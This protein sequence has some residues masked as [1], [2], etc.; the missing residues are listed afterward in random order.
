[1]G[2]RAAERRV[3]GPLGVD[4]D[5]LVVAG[6]LGERVDVVLGDL[7]PLR[8]PEDLACLRPSSPVIVRIGR[9]ITCTR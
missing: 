1:V 6:D 8:G 9:T 3:L 2:D 4:V 7:V 5:P